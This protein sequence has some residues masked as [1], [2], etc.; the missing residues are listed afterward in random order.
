M[1][2]TELSLSVCLSVVISPSSSSSSGV[3]E[4]GVQLG[5][6]QPFMVCVS[7]KAHQPVHLQLT[8]P[9]VGPPTAID[10]SMS[11]SSSSPVVHTEGEALV[12]VGGCDCLVLEGREVAVDAE[13]RAERRVKRWAVRHQDAIKE[14]L[15]RAVG[16]TFD[17]V[18][19]VGGL[20]G[21]IGWAWQAGR[22]PGALVGEVSGISNSAGGRKVSRHVGRLLWQESPRIQLQA[23][24]YQVSGW[25]RQT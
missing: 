4:D 21:A 13:W 18:E 8:A 23:A 2:Y 15:Q 14:G 5:V 12:V 6:H 20:H 24:R 22:Q 10:G 17:L 3:V 11:P 25:L 9:R 19:N 16:L 7:I 1:K